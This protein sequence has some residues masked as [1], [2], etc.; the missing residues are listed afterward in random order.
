LES[1]LEALSGVVK[2]DRKRFLK[3]FHGYVLLRVMQ[4]FGAYGFRGLFQRRPHF[5]KSI[6]FAVRNLQ[7]LLDNWQVEVPLPE[8]TRVFER[9]AGAEQ[10]TD[11]AG[12][13]LPLTVLVESFSYKRGL[14]AY[15]EEHGGGFV[16][17]CRLLPNPGRF[18]K[19]VDQTGQDPE[20]IDFLENCEEVHL[21]LQRVF[22]L[23]P[24]VIE[25]YGEKGYT[26]LHVA[27]GCTGGQHRSVY[28]AERFAEFLRQR[29]G[30]QV[31][32]RHR[33]LK[34]LRRGK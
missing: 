1:Y 10:F 14:P 16:F 31:K 24:H 29:F 15:S 22:D 25:N 33:E 9:I 32:L 19:Y 27:F 2:V 3:H 8:L 34:N 7:T 20:V 18:E 4:T 28:C 5:L 13:Q 6:P 30:V 11:Q 26:E 17:D 23:M 21:F 12:S